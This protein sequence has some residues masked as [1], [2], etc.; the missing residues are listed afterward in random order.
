[1]RG[2][3]FGNGILFVEP[4]ELGGWEVRVE[5]NGMRVPYMGARSSQD[6]MQAYLDRWADRR[7]LQL[8]EVDEVGN[9]VIMDETVDS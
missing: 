5:I 8:V 3:R 9:E 4:R 7:G 6:S 2:Y 1:M